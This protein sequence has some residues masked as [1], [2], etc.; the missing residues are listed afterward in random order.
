[1]KRIVVFS[2]SFV[3]IIVSA[4]SA[5]YNIEG[6]ANLGNLNGKQIL[7]KT[8]DNNCWA[9]LDSANIIHGSF[10][11]KG[12]LTSKSPQVATIFMDNIPLTPLIMESGDIYVNLNTTS[13]SIS[14]TP[15][16][17]KL[18]SFYEE[19]NSLEQKIRTNLPKGVSNQIEDY[20]LNEHQE[21][22]K[23]FIIQNRNNILGST[24]YTI[25]KKNY[26]N[27]L[28]EAEYHILFLES[29]QNDVANYPSE[30]EYSREYLQEFISNYPTD[31]LLW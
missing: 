26:P 7:L 10:S 8:Y 12:H 5:K 11:M 6:T 22:I 16:N 15:L 19:N 20:I 24:I 18:Y 13:L 28:E 2:L 4:C 31:F 30:Q 3:A 29:N 27:L 14:G 9:V 17:N 21:L 23:D 1:M 25:Y